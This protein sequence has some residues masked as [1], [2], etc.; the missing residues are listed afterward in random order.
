MPTLNVRQQDEAIVI[1][2]KGHTCSFRL[3]VPVNA[4]SLMFINEPMPDD[5]DMATNFDVWLH[6]SILGCQEFNAL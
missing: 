1:S 4:A 5:D 3:A 2:F 6:E